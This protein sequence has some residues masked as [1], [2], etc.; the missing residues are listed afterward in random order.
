VITALVPKNL[1]FPVPI[2]IADALVLFAV[3]EVVF[4][5]IVSVFPGFK[6]N[7]I[8]PS[9]KYIPGLVID[10]LSTLVLATF[11]FVVVRVVVELEKPTIV[12]V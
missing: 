9:H 4:N 8:F 1:L 7:P 3:A 10:M 2:S 5:E 11:T 12:L 6:V